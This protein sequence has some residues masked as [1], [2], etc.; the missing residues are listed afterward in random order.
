MQIL[1]PFISLFLLMTYTVGF[2]QGL[3]SVCSH[4]ST[5]RVR[6]ER[7]SAHQHAHHVHE[8]SE[9][10]NHDHVQHRDHFDENAF[11]LL[12]CVLEDAADKQHPSSDNCHCIPTTSNRAAADQ[13]AKMK[14]LAVLVPHFINLQKEELPVEY[15]YSTE[16][17]SISDPF[18][19]SLSQRGPPV[20][21]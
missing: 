18:S 15:S 11:D 7:T 5:V 20:F 19:E 10:E 14:L 2:A 6:T 16:I 4:N 3:T 21:S 1:K 12:M 17:G 9:L 13:L 8:G